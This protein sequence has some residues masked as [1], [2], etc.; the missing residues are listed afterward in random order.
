M[1]LSCA[2]SV[3]VVAL[4]TWAQTPQAPRSP[5]DPSEVAAAAAIYSTMLT[6][7]KRAQEH[8]EL[9]N[10]LSAFR[11]L[12]DLKDSDVPADVRAEAVKRIASI[13]PV[14]D[15]EQSSPRRMA[16]RLVSWPAKVLIWLIVIAMPLWA[17]RYLLF[18]FPRR[19]TRVSFEDLSEPRDTRLAKS[20]VLTNNTRD[21]LQNP[22]PVQMSE[23]HVDLMPGTDEG[24]FSGLSPTLA[25]ESVLG[26]EPSD[27]P[28]KV[29]SLE[30]S[31]QDLFGL[32][33][34]FFSRLYEHDLD[35]WLD[36]RGDQVEAFAELRT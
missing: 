32:L 3:S 2:F 27:H 4:A 24:G 14:L 22:K 25:M 11:A 33:S 29:A 20:R 34:S 36:I 30:F 12:A 6:D 5:R 9:K 28:V 19:A 31:L 26:F 16:I 17:Y 10:A 35:G 21:L 23:L 18:R 15:N 8:G 7:A 1:L 13:Q